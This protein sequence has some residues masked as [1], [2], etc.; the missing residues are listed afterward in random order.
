MESLLIIA[1]VLALILVVVFVAV[2][3]A[4]VGEETDEGFRVIEPSGFQRFKARLRRGRKPKNR[5][6]LLGNNHPVDLT[7]KLGL[8]TTGG[9]ILNRSWSRRRCA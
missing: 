8:Q 1:A 9:S 2:W 4:P 3:T 6:G 7:R 5:V